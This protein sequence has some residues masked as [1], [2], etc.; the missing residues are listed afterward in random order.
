MYW[1]IGTPR[2]YATSSSSK[3]SARRLFVSHDGLS[4]QSQ[5][6]L[7]TSPTAPA[8]RS[9]AQIRDDVDIQAPPSPATL[10]TTAVHTAE[11]DE[12]HASPSSP[13]NS[14]ESCSVDDVPL[15]DPVLALRVSRSGNLF[16][17]ITATSITVWQTKV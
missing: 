16:V 8:P 6:S 4:N 9:R 17:V 7:T 14:R 13:G 1:P 11:N 10:N 12:Q 5:S 15:K 3:A 2:I